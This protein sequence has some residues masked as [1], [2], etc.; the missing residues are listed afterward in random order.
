MERIPSFDIVKAIALGA[1]IFGHYSFGG[2]PTSLVDF[3]CS[4]S[5]PTFFFISGYFCKKEPLGTKAIKKSTSSL[6][7]PYAITST[8]LIYLPAMRATLLPSE[9]ILSTVTTWIVAG[10]YG[11]DGVFPDMPK[12]SSQ[13]ERPGTFGPSSGA[14]FF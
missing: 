8:L 5:M 3:S 2:T 12:T 10:L 13:S 6:L 7:I 9:R 1:V 11:S 14:R 4:F